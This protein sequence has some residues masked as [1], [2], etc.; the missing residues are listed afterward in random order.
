[1]PAFT[2]IAVSAVGPT[3]LSTA[4]GISSMFRQVGA[5]LGVAAFVA[6]VATP[7][8]DQAIEAYRNG[9]IFMAAAAA[10]G[11]ILILAA[12]FAPAPTVRPPSQA[13]SAS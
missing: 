6:I 5:A 2:A 12:R 8:R 10:V 13:L 1:M 3:R 11:A 9:W 7:E 4:L